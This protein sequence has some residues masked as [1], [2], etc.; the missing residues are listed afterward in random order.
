MTARKTA[1]PICLNSQYRTAGTEQDSLGRTARTGKPD[2]ATLDRLVW[3]V[4]LDRPA[5]T[6]WPDSSGWTDSPGQDKEDRKVRAWQQG[7]TAATRQLGH[8]SPI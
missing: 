1:T 7:M 2:Q 3:L 5:G 8:D 6:D 4:S